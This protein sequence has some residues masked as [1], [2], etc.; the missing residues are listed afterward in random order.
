MSSAMGKDKVAVF[1]VA[2][3]QLFS[4]FGSHFYREDVAGVE[5]ELIRD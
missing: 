4:G 3:T 2:K 1:L 5:M